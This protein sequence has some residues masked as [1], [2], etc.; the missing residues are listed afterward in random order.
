MTQNSDLPLQTAVQRPALMVAFKAAHPD[1][2]SEET[3]YGPVATSA[4]ALLHA[5]DLL[6]SALEDIAVARLLHPHA[7]TGS[8]L[9][10]VFDMF[11]HARR[12]LALKLTGRDFAAIEAH[13]NTGHR[14]LLSCQPF[15]GREILSLGLA[16][17]RPRPYGKPDSRDKHPHPDQQT[18]LP[19]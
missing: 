16:P 5:L 1:T 11:F 13:F 10:T 3:L 7:R 6:G 18:H 19:R 9:Q 14:I 15:G 12:E 4:Q 17:V 2:R 8:L